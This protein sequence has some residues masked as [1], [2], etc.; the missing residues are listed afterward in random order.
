MNKAYLDE[1][2]DILDDMGL[3]SQWHSYLTV[4]TNV[5]RFATYYIPSMRFDGSDERAEYFDYT[6]DVSL[7]TRKYF[8]DAD[9]EFEETFEERLRPYGRFQKASGYD[10][11]HELFT[12]TYRLE[13]KEFFESE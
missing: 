13:F 6:L 3:Q 4:P 11:E 10:S 9:M 8:N 5:H 2:R 7:H 1:I 12:S